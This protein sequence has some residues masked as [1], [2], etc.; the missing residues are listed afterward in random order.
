MPAFIHLPCPCGRTL[1]AGEDQAGSSIR[2]WG[3]GGEVVV[4][5]PKVGDRLWGEFRRSLR[6]ALR[7]GFFFLA[8]GFGMV[9]SLLLSVPYAG[10]W[11]GLAFALIMAVLYQDAIRAAGEGRKGERVGFS[12]LIRNGWLVR[13]P[14]AALAVVAL[15]APVYFRNWGQLLPGARSLPIERT[16]MMFSF[17]M[18]LTVPLVL[19]AANA[20]D[21]A[22]RLDSSQAFLTMGN[23]PRAI[24]FAL[25]VLP[26]GLCVIEFGLVLFAWYENVLPMYVCDLFPTPMKVLSDD[27]AK[28]LI[29]YYDLNSYER[30]IALV[31]EN[32]IP[33]YIR[34]MRRGFFLSGTIPESVASGWNLRFEPEFFGLSRA[35]YF[36]ARFLFSVLT[37]AATG[38][39]LAVQSHWLGL[40]AAIGSVRPNSIAKDSGR[41]QRVKGIA[42]IER[43]SGAPDDIENP[44]ITVE[45]RHD[46]LP[47]SPVLPPIPSTNSHS[48]ASPESITPLFILPASMTPIATNGVGITSFVA[49]RSTI[50]IIDDERTFAHAIGKIIA[51]RGFAVVVACDGEEG[52]RLAQTCRPDLIILDLLLPDRPGM[53]IC[54]VLRTQEATREIP[55]IVASYKSGTEDEIGALS[56]GADDFIGKPYAI[57]V[58]IARIEKQLARRRV[59]TV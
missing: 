9:L 32:G 42:P 18:W 30:P 43:F 25:L 16:L 5:L 56:Q 58:L 33:D 1:R 48:I 46:S 4:P 55:I 26:I 53:E 24:F 54:Q 39:V 20:H 17:V 28:Y 31:Q 15:F 37:L 36:I 51:D 45:S 2:C 41:V 13:W 3:C 22:G 6:N 14:L 40:I 12:S 38:T 10:R 35:G 11:L 49:G 34:A 19:L 50:L 44:R 59:R 21:G 23:H 27:G 52:L 57:E 7:P 29:F 8:L 47:R